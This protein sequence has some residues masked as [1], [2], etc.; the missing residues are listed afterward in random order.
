MDCDLVASPY[1]APMDK[2]SCDREEQAIDIIRALPE[3]WYLEHVD[4]RVMKQVLAKAKHL[5]H[6][7]AP[8]DD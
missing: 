4:L 7:E 3:G 8:S 1:F 2:C 6:I 5:G